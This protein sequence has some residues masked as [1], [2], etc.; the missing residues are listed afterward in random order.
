M[1]RERERD[2]L[3]ATG[4]HGSTMQSHAITQLTQK[5]GSQASSAVEMR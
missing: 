4:T 1:H 3:E 5:A 2:I